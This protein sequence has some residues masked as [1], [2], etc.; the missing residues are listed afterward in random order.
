MAPNLCQTNR[1]ADQWEVR[2]VEA[3]AARLTASL[4]KKSTR[5]IVEDLLSRLRKKRERREST[6]GNHWE[7][8]CPSYLERLV[9]KF[10]VGDPLRQVVR[11]IVVNHDSAVEFAS[12]ITRDAYLAETA[13]S[14]TYIELLKG[15]TTVTLFYHSLKMNARDLLRRRATERQR[16]DSLDTMVSAARATRALASEPVDPDAAEEI[17]FP[18]T[19]LEDQDPLEILLAKEEHRETNDEI[20]YAVRNVRCRGNRW[21][22]QTEWW[23][24]SGLATLAKRQRGSDFGGSCE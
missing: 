24:E 2:L 12:R 23:K 21:I 16:N 8:Y 6:G 14:Q 11:F 10:R 3:A 13:V 22:L 1:T 18:S 17:D 5:E 7:S 20:E 9:T 19:R 4:P 15:Q